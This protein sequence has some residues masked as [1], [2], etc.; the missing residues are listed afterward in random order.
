MSENNL[1]FGEKKEWFV[2]GN[3]RSTTKWDLDTLE[4]SK[5]PFLAP[6]DPDEHDLVASC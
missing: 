2:N 6:V 1:C 5:V 4:I 3:N